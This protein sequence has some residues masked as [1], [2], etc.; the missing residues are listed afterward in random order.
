[1]K[2]LPAGARDQLLLLPCLARAGGED[3]TQIRLHRF[4][5]FAPVLF[6]GVPA[7]PVLKAQRCLD[8]GGKLSRL[9]AERGRKKR[10]SP[11]GAIAH[12]AEDSRRFRRMGS[13]RVGFRA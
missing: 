11:K 12:G 8:V 13:D 1:V 7:V 10:V 6:L 3:L 5:R 4:A 2:C 9:R